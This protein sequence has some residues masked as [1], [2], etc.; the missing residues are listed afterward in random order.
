MI[1]QLFPYP[2]RLRAMA[3]LLLVYVYSGLRWLV[4]QSGLLKLLPPRL[5]QLEELQPAVTPHNV[6]TRLPGRTPA[7][8]AKRHTVALV[9]G[10]VQRVFNPSVNEATLRVLAAEGC[11]VIVPRGQGC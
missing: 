8:G 7:L 6:F 9:A 3:A 5:R 2:G 1:F 4:R 11:E 10:C